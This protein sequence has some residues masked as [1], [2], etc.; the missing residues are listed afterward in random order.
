MLRYFQQ[1][2]DPVWKRLDGSEDAL[3]NPWQHQFVNGDIAA[4]IVGIW[5]MESQCTAFIVLQGRVPSPTGETALGA[6][7]KR[8]NRLI[9]Y[10]CQPTTSPFGVCYTACNKN[11]EACNQRMVTILS[12]LRSTYKT[13]TATDSLSRAIQNHDDV[14]LGPY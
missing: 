1:P 5:T 14:I 13:E 6:A 10:L 2:G 9:M 8:G 3:E 4:Y 7:S 12:S 11:L